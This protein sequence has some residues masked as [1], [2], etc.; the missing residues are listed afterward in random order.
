MPAQQWGYQVGEAEEVE[1]TGEGDSRDAVQRGGDPGYLRLV[2]G[3]VGGDGSVEALFGE[4]RVA[5]GVGD[6]ACGCV[7]VWVY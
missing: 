7:S 5:F 4:D 2:D 6:V 1:G 3:E